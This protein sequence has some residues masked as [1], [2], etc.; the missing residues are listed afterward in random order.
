MQ[1]QG[2]CNP[3]GNILIYSNYDGGNLDIVLD[4]NIPDIRIGI[5]SYES[6]TINI[7]GPY[8]GNVTQVL[9]AGYDNDGTTSV[10]GVDPGIVD[11]LLYPP[12]YLYDPDGY[13]YMICAYECD[14]TYV[15]GG[16]NTV[17]QAVDYFATELPGTIRYGYFQYTVFTGSY[18]MSDGGNCCVGASCVAVIDAGQD[19]TICLGD[20]TLLNVVG[21]EVYAWS[22]AT[23]LSDTGIE[24]PFAFPSSTT[25]YI[26]TGTDADGCV[27]ADSVTV[28]VE[29]IPAPEI[30]ITG[31]TLSVTEGTTWQWYLDGEMIPGA[32][33]SSYEVMENGVYS[34]IVTND[35]GCSGESNTVSM[36]LEAIDDEILYLALYPN[37]AD[38]YL[39]IQI[40]TDAGGFTYRV[41]NSAGVD[42][43]QGNATGNSTQI[44][45]H[46][47]PDGIYHVVTQ[48]AM[49]SGHAGFII[50]H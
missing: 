6:L 37:P 5:C 18:A 9:Y 43:I 7:S 31:S 50:L 30:I 23:G 11:I 22:P 13:P 45:V 38:R 49:T 24:N 35:A 33:A 12:V 39:T 27:G 20:S 46:T 3:A 29:P 1:A 42:V 4:E 14:T 36:I 21:A 10:S 48:N 25:T 47:L 44:D 41:L 34:V 28:F 26:V 2:I 16:C 15:P 40:S 32:T 8:T 17:D 19:E